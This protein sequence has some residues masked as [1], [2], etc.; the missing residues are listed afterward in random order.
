MK[1]L[2]FSVLS[3]ALFLITTN[4]SAYIHNQY[5]SP[6]GCRHM[7]ASLSDALDPFD[8]EYGLANWGKVRTYSPQQ[9]VICPLSQDT[10]ETNVQEWGESSVQSYDFVRLHFWTINST[11]QAWA[12][13]CQ[14]KF[15]NQNTVCGGWYQLLGADIQFSIYDIPNT[16]YPAGGGYVIAI[17]NGNYSG[18]QDTWINGYHASTWW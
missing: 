5:Y 2:V 17:V 14:I 11:N 16:E 13:I 8:Y 12:A 10:N 4:A 18:Q 1:K 6:A 9:V 7:N 3:F 15:S